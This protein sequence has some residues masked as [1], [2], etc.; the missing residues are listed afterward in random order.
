MRQF[1]GIFQAVTA[2]GVILSWAAVRFP[3]VRPRGYDPE[4]FFAASRALAKKVVCTMLFHY[5]LRKRLTVLRRRKLRLI[6]EVR[7]PIDRVSL[8][9]TMDV[10]SCDIMLYEQSIDLNHQILLPVW[11]QKIGTDRL[12]S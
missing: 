1:A 8:S 7:L 10:M 12:E 9:D 2:V 4:A 11:I 3:P 6:V 5:P